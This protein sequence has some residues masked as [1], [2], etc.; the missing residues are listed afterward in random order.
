MA[1][2][3]LWNAGDRPRVWINWDSFNAQGIP[4]ASRQPFQD[5]VINA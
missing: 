4:N 2:Q 3:A 1:D 5:A